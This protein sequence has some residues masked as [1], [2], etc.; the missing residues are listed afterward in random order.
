[1]TWFLL[2]NVLTPLRNESRNCTPPNR[3]SHIYR[4][5]S[6]SYRATLEKI[7]IVEILHCNL[8]LSINVSPS[9]KWN[10]KIH[11]FIYTFQSFLRW[12]LLILS[13][14]YCIFWIRLMIYLNQFYR[15]IWVSGDFLNY[16][17]EVKYKSIR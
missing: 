15:L 4:Y 11:S 16:S 9:S 13:W 7:F 14:R 8:V 17:H 2:R 5:R 1:M 10:E 3:F 12:E 6:L